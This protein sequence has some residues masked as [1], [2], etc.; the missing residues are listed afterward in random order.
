MSLLLVL[1][2]CATVQWLGYILDGFVK[3]SKY[4]LGY[5]AVATRVSADGKTTVDDCVSPY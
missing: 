5:I 4:T 3:N 1:P 2:I